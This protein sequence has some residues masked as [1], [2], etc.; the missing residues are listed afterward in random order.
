MPPVTPR[1]W[2]PG[3]AWRTQ[4]CSTRRPSM[5]CRQRSTPPPARCCRRSPRAVAGYACATTPCPH[6]PASR[7]SSSARSQVR[8]LFVLLLYAHLP[9]S[10]EAMACAYL[11]TCVHKRIVH[12]HPS[13]D[14]STCACSRDA[15]L[16]ITKPYSRGRMLC[17]CALTRPAAGAAACAG[18]LLLVLCL[19]MAACV[20]SASFA[21]FLVRERECQSK[22]LQMIAG[23]PAGAFWAATYAWDLLSF[24][25]PALGAPAGSWRICCRIFLTTVQSSAWAAC[26]PARLGLHVP[27]RQPSVTHLWTLPVQPLHA[28]K[29][30][31]RP[32]AWQC[33]S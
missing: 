7:P 1:C 9:G 24:S 33:V 3:G 22:A 11:Q 21:V 32:G 6:C 14:S 19:T 17:V 27:V 2:R 5:A 26:S 16:P 30:S 13:H 25:V 20:L 10:H 8:V 12:S 29:T 4:S 28:H 23:A 15:R 18:D 31:C